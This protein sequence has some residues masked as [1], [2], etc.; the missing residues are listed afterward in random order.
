[1]L[2]QLVAYVGQRAVLR[3]AARATSRK[4][5]WGNT[6]LAD[7]LAELE[8]TSGRDLSTW[9]KL[10]LQTAGVNT[11]RPERRRSTTDGRHHG[12]VD[13]PDRGR[14]L[15]DAAPAP[16]RRRPA[17]TVQRRPAACARTGSSWTSTASAPRCPSW[18]AGRARPAAGQRR[19][20]GL[21]QDPPRRALAG[22]RGRAPARLRRLACP[23]AL[24]WGAAWD[25][26]RD[27]EMPGPRLRRPG[28]SSI[29]AGRDRL[30]A[31]CRRCCASC[32]RTLA[33]VRRARAPRG[34]ARPTA[35]SP[36]ARRWL[37]RPSRAA[38]PSC[39]WSRAFAGMPRRRRRTRRTCGRCS[40]ASDRARRAG[41]RHRDALDAADRPGRRPARPA[42]P[43][44]RP[45]C[46]RDNTAT[47][48]ERA[49]ARP[50]RA[51]RPPRPR[52]TAWQQ[53]R[54]GRRAAQP[55]V[56]PRSIIGLR[57]GARPRSCSR[58][59]SSRT[60]TR[61]LHGVGRADARDRPSRSS[62]GCLPARCW[63]SRELADATQ[64][65]AGR[66]RRRPGRPAPAGVGG[67]RRHRPG[68]APPRSGTP[69]RG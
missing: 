8:Q 47:G 26:T 44:S 65:L 30:D 32:R 54:R 67:P 43:R 17:T 52:P 55:T 41:H 25:M 45:S 31:C 69:P 61:S 16:P 56:R 48:R 59:T 3:R 18:S 14:G 11:L 58:P 4:H 7:L 64:R 66:A 27:A 34:R 39:S 62:S 15:P 22:H 51:A 42:T 35:A 5:A 9:S 68:A 57:P 28:R 46:E 53:R 2:K 63:P 20:P 33:I 13:H 19:R 1:M 60:S 38:T 23:R 12:R 10:W 50:G 49:A 21:R 37:A 24:V 6:T 36:A 29:A 40:T